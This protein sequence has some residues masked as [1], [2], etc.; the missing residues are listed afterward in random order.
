MR[1]NWLKTQ[2]QVNPLL[3]FF[4]LI[5]EKV[6]IKKGKYWNSIPAIN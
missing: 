5:L 3:S 6:L 4:R 1:G 2:R